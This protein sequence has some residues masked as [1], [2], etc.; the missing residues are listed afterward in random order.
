MSEAEVRSF[1]DRYTAAFSALDVSGILGHFAFPCQI[2]TETAGYAFADR[3]AIEA[4]MTGFVRFYAEQD[5]ARAE[6]ARLDYQPLSETFGLA[7]VNWRLVETGGE[8]LVDVESTYI[9][10]TG[11]G[12]PS[13]IGILGHNEDGQWQRKGVTAG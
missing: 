2:A 8:I 7:H 12:T 3:A 10:R 6:L 13:I 1:F 11:P 5:F 4:D 9:L